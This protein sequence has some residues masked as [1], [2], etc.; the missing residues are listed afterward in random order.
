M[1]ID[2]MN[3]NKAS[4]KQNVCGQHVC[5][6]HVILKSFIDKVWIFNNEITT[7]ESYSKKYPPEYSIDKI[8]LV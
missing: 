7:S 3:F 2:F 6:I 4:N 1:S 8:W 5:I